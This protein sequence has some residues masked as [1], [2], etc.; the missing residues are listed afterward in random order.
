[1]AF[2][3]NACVK[4]GPIPSI[5]C[6]STHLTRRL[7]HLLADSPARSIAVSFKPLKPET[8]AAV[9]LVVVVLA[10]AIQSSI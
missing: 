7:T 10:A 9:E 3:S 8:I 5:L 1:M 6:V 2:I 4:L